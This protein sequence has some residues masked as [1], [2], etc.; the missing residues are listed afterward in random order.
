MEYGFIQI[1]R[2]LISWEWFADSKT[3]HVFMYLLLNANHRN[4]KW[5]GVTVKRGQ[6]L[7]GRIKISEATGISQQSVRTALSNLI[8]TNEITIE[9][10]NRFSIITICNYNKYQDVKNEINQPVNQLP[11]SYQPATNQLPTTNKNEKN[12]KKDKGVKIIHGEFKNVRLTQEEHEK[13]KTRFNGSCQEKIEKLS[14]YIASKGKKYASHYATIL[15]WSRS[16]APPAPAK[17]A[18]SNESK[19]EVD[20][21]I[22]EGIL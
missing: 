20:R 19:S 2:Q 4:K 13:L 9:P 12:E 10:T 17:E 22:A 16:D 6:T 1:H 21:L 7:T 18:V 15:S 14:E 5:R 3:F 8:T 11:T